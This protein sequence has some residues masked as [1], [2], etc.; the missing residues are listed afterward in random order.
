MEKYNIEV[1]EVIT[2]KKE[3]LPSVFHYSLGCLHHLNLNHIK[4]T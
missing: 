3:L 2:V 4:L 1:T